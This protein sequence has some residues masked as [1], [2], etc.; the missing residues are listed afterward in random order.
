MYGTMASG[1]EAVAIVDIADPST[2][3]AMVGIIA[4]SGMLQNVRSRRLFTMDEVAM[5]RKTAKEIAGAYK[6]PGQ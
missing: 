6:A 5:F 2:E 1:P 3:V 4:S